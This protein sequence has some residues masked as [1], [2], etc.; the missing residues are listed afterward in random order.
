MTKI[1]EFEK[2][3]IEN[4][5]YEDDYAEYEK[6]LKR[7][8]DNFLC[9]Q[10]CYITALHFPPERSEQAINLI[11][12]GLS[13]Y[14]TS[15]FP[16]YSAYCDI[17]IINERCGKYQAAYDVYMKAYDILGEEHLSYQQ[18]LAGDI[19][20]MLFHIDGFRYSEKLE[21]YY[22]MFKEIDDFQKAFITNEFR[23]A[24]SEIIIF[25]HYEMK[26]KALQAYKEASRLSNPKT[27]SRV[28]GIL[29]KHRAQDTLKFIAITFKGAKQNL[30]R[31]KAAEY[32]DIIY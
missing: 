18:S 27:V 30:W 2:K 23:L 14:P 1:E 26:D 24:I 21:N 8:H 32:N 19:L 15:W 3:L 7:V 17:G 22:N 6:R 25:S 16:T 10:H 9:L 13:K 11:E 29:D 28:Q 20:W 31:R 5:M 12:W 4:G